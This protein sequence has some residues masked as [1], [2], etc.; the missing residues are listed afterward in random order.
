MLLPGNLLNSGR[1][2]PVGKWL[3]VLVQDSVRVFVII[4]NRLF[5]V[6]YAVDLVL[7]KPVMKQNLRTSPSP[8]LLMELDM[9]AIESNLETLK[10]FC[11]PGQRFIA[12]VKAN[13]Y[14][15]G[16]VEVSRE[17]QR[18]GVDMLATG[19]PGEARDM[20]RHGIELPIMLF[21]FGSPEQTAEAVD[22]GYIPTVTSFDG[23][24]AISARISADTSIYVKVDAGLG[25]LGIVLEQAKSIIMGIAGLPHIHIGGIYTHVPFVDETGRQW[26]RQRLEKFAALLSDLEKSGLRPEVTQAVAS[27][28]LLAK[29][30]DP[31]NTV[32]VGHALY[33]LSPY[34][35][36]RVADMSVIKPVVAAI[37][38]RL[39]HIGEHP[40]GSDIAITGIFD[41][42]RQQ[43]LGIL[44]VGLSNGI[45]GAGPARKYNVLIKGS[46]VPVLS[47]SLEHTTIDLS[48]APECKVGDRAYFVG[49]SGDCML[50]LD[51]L[52]ASWDVL[53]LEALMQIST[54]GNIGIE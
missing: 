53:P 43:R 33:G 48:D 51:D 23:A 52:S 1:P 46:H 32:C 40:A 9:A 39:I 44:P 29:L 45:H 12:S 5:L 28:C 25:R 38:S 30:D 42:E 41:L 20:R 24:A 17:L 18:L 7:C 13:A 10:A 35:D 22:E 3:V 14:G 37:S 19:N 16:V 31:C 47:V 11:A 15:L 49:T 4:S 26:A 2:H 36:Q 54:R 34:G 6:V 27:S 21:A 50:E 8:A